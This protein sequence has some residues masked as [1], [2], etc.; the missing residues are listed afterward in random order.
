ML[1][2]KALQNIAAGKAVPWK[3]RVYILTRTDLLKKDRHGVYAIQDDV[4]FD[5]D[6]N[7]ILES[8]VR[9]EAFVEA[10]T[11]GA[12]DVQID[13]GNRACSTSRGVSERGDALRPGRRIV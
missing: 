13:Y 4:M 1:R 6:I 8:F 7:L 5:R 3:M 11:L 2:E 12:V 9:M 10:Y